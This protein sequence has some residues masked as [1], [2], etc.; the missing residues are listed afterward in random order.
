M[1]HQFEV[2]R[3]L[4]RT[5]ETVTRVVI[6]PTTK[7]RASSDHGYWIA[8][9]AINRMYPSASIRPLGISTRQ[10]WEVA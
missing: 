10:I 3:V 2:T 4:K 8:K 9:A 1:F 7:S 5:D 6:I